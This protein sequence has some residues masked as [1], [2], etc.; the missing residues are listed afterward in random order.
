MTIRKRENGGEVPCG[1][2]CAHGGEARGGIA[3]HGERPPAACADDEILASIA[4]GV[5]PAHTGAELAEAIGEE[6]LPAIV[7]EE[8]VDVCVSA[9]ERSCIDEE[10]RR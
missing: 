5:D 1:Q 4:V 8:G 2:R 9:E 7:V 10:W 3:Q 6:R